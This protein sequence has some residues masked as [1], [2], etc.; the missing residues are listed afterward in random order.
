MQI[1]LEK[2]FHPLL[3]NSSKSNKKQEAHLWVPC[4]YNL[5]I[6]SNSKQP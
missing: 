4:V 3:I 6:A 5:I 1:N 2:N